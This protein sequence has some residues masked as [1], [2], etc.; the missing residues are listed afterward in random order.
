MNGIPLKNQHFLHFRRSSDTSFLYEAQPS[1][2]DL[3]ITESEER[4]AEALA[5]IG[6]EPQDTL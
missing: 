6:A 1:T 2:K 5:D 4:M 3:E